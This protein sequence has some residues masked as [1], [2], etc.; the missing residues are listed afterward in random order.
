MRG[1]TEWVVYLVEC[2]DGSLY[3]GV[4]KDLPRR[5]RQHNGEVAGGAKY[6]RTRKP[7]RLVAFKQS[8]TPRQEEYR[9]KRLNRSQK[10]QLVRGPE[11]STSLKKL[12]SGPQQTS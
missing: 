8:A 10:L 1:S 3:T 11:W 12:G 4:T 5:L 9:I 6:T 7:V 2:S